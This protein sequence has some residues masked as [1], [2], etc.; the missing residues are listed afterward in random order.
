M[1]ASNPGAA[2]RTSGLLHG[3]TALSSSN[4]I[5]VSSMSSSVISGDAYLRDDIWVAVRTG[6]EMASSRKAECLH[7][8][9]TSKSMQAQRG[10][11]C[12]PRGNAAYLILSSSESG[13]MD[14]AV[15]RCSVSSS[16]DERGVSSSL[17]VRHD[18]L[19]F[20]IK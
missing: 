13:W 11:S 4:N 20:Q 9:K 19:C 8:T 16:A 2:F 1:S 15:L 18:C 7:D 6:E 12:A 5:S 14:W 3:S 10:T 17:P